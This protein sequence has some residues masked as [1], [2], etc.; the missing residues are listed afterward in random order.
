MLSHLQRLYGI[1]SIEF[2]LEIRQE[3][4]QKHYRNSIKNWVAKLF[5]IIVR[6]LMNI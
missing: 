1:A 3:F 6:A 2:P 5:L 4:P